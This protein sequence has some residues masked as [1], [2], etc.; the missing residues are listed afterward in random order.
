[1]ANL[2]SVVNSLRGHGD[3]CGTSFLWGD[4]NAN[5]GQSFPCLH[6]DRSGVSSVLAY[7]ESDKKIAQK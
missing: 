3:Q 5:G 4:R 6:R 7:G 2:Y 1:M